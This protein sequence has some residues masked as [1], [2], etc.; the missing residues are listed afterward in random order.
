MGAGIDFEKEIRELL[1]EEGS[2]LQSEIHNKLD[3]RVNW[4]DD[5]S[6]GSIRSKVSDVMNILEI[7][8][9]IEIEEGHFPEHGGLT[10]KITYVGE[11]D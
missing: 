8:E 4:S 6:R 11:D 3:E 7:K 1:Q 9:E 2:I 10:N 5:Y